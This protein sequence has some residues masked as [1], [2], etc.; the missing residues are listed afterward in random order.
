MKKVQRFDIQ[1]LDEVETTAAGFLRFTVFAGRTG[2]QNYKQ[3]DGSTFKEFRPAKEVFDEKTL[4]SLRGAP[5]TNNHPKEM[6]T[7]KNSRDLMVGFVG[8]TIERIKR[9]KI[10]FQKA[11]VTVSDAGTI[12]DIKKGKLEVSLGYDLTLDETPGEFD[13]ERYDAIQTDIK[14]NHLALVDIARGGEQVR[15]R[16]DAD[17]A[18]QRDCNQSSSA[19]A[20]GGDTDNNHNQ[21]EGN[22]A[23][24]KIGDREFDLD[25][26][27]A[28]AVKGLVDTTEKLRKKLKGLEG[29]GSKS[30]E[31]NADIDKLQARIDHLESELAGAK[32]KAGK[33]DDDTFKTALQERR[34]IEKVAEKTL[35][36]EDAEK[37]EKMGN[38]ELKKAVITAESKV[39]VDLKEKS[40]SYIDARFDQICDTIDVSSE[41]T[42]KAGKAVGDERTKKADQEASD[43]EDGDDELAKKRKESMKKDSERWKQPS[44]TMRVSDAYAARLAANGG[45]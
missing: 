14:I 24:V 3:A 7:P 5:F 10:E 21:E 38:T 26:D 4:D 20:N 40:D 45:K 28:S 17:D 16:M 19:G 9:G 36:K 11:K 1:K 34:K 37:I 12:A 2:I 8:D 22:M 18:I 42:K 43:N 31:D 13:G 15:L 32:E 27:A 25:K 39:D 6:I 33:M 35:S 41:A 29:K 23:K 44:P 30:D